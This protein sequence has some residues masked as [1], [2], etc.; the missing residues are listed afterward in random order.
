M[1]VPG[2]REQYPVPVVIVSNGVSVL[3]YAIGVYI[4]FKLSILLVICYLVFILILEFRLLRGHCI[5]CYYYG[6]TCAFG[7][8]RLS[9][10]FFRNGQIE[11]FNQGTITWKD[12]IPDFLVFIIPMIAGI[13]LLVQEFT[14]VILVLLVILFL[15]GFAGNAFVRSHLAC[16][17]CRQREIGCPA[18]TLFNKTKKA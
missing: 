10:L 9:A 4:L 18:E 14:W 7:K 8:G 2:C 17:Y 12:I 6:K 5:N 13:V 1:Q 16:P 11:A 15:L 3:I